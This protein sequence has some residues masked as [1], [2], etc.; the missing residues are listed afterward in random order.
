[1]TDC[2]DLKRNFH[3]LVEE[4][5]AC[6]Y[7]KPIDPRMRYEKIR[8][9]VWRVHLDLHPDQMRKKPERTEATR[10]P[11]TA[12]AAVQSD[13]VQLVQLYH[14]HRFHKADYLPKPHEILRAKTL[15]QEH[16]ATVLAGLAPSVARMV[17]R[18]Y[19][20]QDVYF[21]SAVPFFVTA[22]ARVEKQQRVRTRQESMDDA[23]AAADAAIMEEKRRRFARREQLLRRWAGLSHDERA[24]CIQTAIEAAHTDFDRRRLSR[25]HVENDPPREVLDAMDTDTSGSDPVDRSPAATERAARVPAAGG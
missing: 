22:A 19:H 10:T 13:A 6:G 23:E 24:K 16:D 8:L 25:P 17:Q 7:L 9:G 20:G 1:M 5:E 15:L 3:C 18:Q 4:L 2:K 21:G 11:T 12:A 14:H